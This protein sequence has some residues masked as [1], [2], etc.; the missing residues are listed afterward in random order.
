MSR[1]LK[2]LSKM[3]LKQLSLKKKLMPIIMNKLL[4][5][6]KVKRKMEIKNDLT[7]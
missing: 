3:Q 2:K 1:Q 5:Q 4:S 6:M 7:I